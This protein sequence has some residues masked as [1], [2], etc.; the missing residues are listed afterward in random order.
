M[1]GFSRRAQVDNPEMHVCT[2]LRSQF[3]REVNL[4]RYLTREMRSLTESC[5]LDD[6]DCLEVVP[7]TT[8]YD[9]DAIDLSVVEVSETTQSPDDLEESSGS[10]DMEENLC[11]E[12]I[13][14]TTPPNPNSNPVPG[15]PGGVVDTTDDDGGFGG[16]EKAVGSSLV[17]AMSLLLLTVISSWL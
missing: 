15:K 7:T 12:P 6:E 11:R 14:P 4:L 2:Q 8:Y 1:V 13:P 17:L 10:G 3:S 16:A 5:S 9:L